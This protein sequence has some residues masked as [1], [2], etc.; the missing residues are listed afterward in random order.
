MS[1]ENGWRKTL[2]KLGH[3][4]TGLVIILKGYTKFEDHDVLLGIILTAIGFVFV[5]FSIFHE[6]IKWIKKHESWL[7]W[8]DSLAIGIVAYSYFSH[9]KVAIPILYAFSSIMLFSV[10]IY[11]YKYRD[12]HK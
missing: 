8:L 4:I 11:F 7:F 3:I 1:D 12:S 5:S 2:G 9:G 10:G 6:K